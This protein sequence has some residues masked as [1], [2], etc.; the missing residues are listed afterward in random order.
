M[1]VKTTANENKDK[2][3]PPRSLAFSLSLYRFSP[4]PKYLAVR[5]SIALPSLLVQLL[6][7]L[8]GPPARLGD[9]LRDGVRQGTVGGPPRRRSLDRLLPLCLR[10]GLPGRLHGLVGLGDRREE[11]LEPLG[12]DGA[13]EDAR[14]ADGKDGPDSPL[15]DFGLF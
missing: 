5:Y 2:K 15:T 6:L 8:L 1:K 9:A 11:L 7:L 12:G 14:G 3:T 4:P 13:A 10:R